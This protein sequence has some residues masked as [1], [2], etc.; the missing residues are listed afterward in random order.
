MDSF[1][2]RRAVIL[3]KLLVLILILIYNVMF[4]GVF[5]PL[6]KW[7]IQRLLPVLMQ[8]VVVSVLFPQ[9][10]VSCVMWLVLPRVHNIYYLNTATT[11]SEKPFDVA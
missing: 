6:D 4:R 9:S 3:I 10:L 7:L 1:T 11:T 5:V 2:P 8:Q